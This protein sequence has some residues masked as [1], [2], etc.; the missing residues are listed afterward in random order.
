MITL[1]VYAALEAA[2]NKY[3]TDVSPVCIAEAGRTIPSVRMD[4]AQ[5]VLADDVVRD[6]S[7][8]AVNMNDLAAPASD[9]LNRIH[10]LH[11]GMAGLPLETECVARYF[12]E[13]KL[14]R[15]R[16]ECN[17]AAAAIPSVAA[18]FESDPYALA[19]RKLNKGVNT[20]TKSGMVSRTLSA[21]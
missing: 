14:P 18:V 13:D 4:A 19:L 6:G 21:G 2:L 5:T 11:N 1:D 17:I 12:V 7:I 16:A 15:L 9:L 20:L 8:L 10:Q 3:G